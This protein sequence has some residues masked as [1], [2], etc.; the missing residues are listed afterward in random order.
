VSIKT[1]CLPPLQGDLSDAATEADRG[2]PLRSGLGWRS[3][4]PKA[5]PLNAA[6][7]GLVEGMRRWYLWCFLGWHDIR[8]RYRRSFIGPFWLTLSMGILVGSLGFLYSSLF[9]QDVSTF[10]PYLAAGFIFWGFISTTILESCGTFTSAEG[11]IKQVP[12]PL[13][14]HVLRGV[15]RNV[16]ILLHNLAIWVAV[17]LWFWIPLTWSTLLLV[18]GFILVCA[19]LLWIGL[20]L[21]VVC[22]RFRDVAQIVTNAVQIA[23]FLSPILWKPDFIHHGAFI[24]VDSNPFFHLVSIVR[25]P[26]LGTAPSSAS[27]LFCIT[28]LAVGWIL[29]VVTFLRCRRFVPY[30]L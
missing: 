14:V 20:M 21:A 10:L 17:A 19:N 26:L 22:A 28:M 9:K 27:W 8:Q 2:L 7:F 24:L 13:V 18:P 11:I 5:S 4:A 15:A 12:M 16:V 23:F 3:A 6:L 30:W 1:D 25:E 29:A